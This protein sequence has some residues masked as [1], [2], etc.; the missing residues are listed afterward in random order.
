MCGG[1]GSVCFLYGR[2][3]FVSFGIL[4]IYFLIVC[5]FFVNTESRFDKRTCYRFKY[6]E[7]SNYYNAVSNIKIGILA[8]EF[9]MFVRSI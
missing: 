7:E 2:K 3:V 9:F 1:E 6:L 4:F 5:S 8:H